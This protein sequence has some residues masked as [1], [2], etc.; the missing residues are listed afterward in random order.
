[1]KGKQTTKQVRAGEVSCEHATWH[2][3][4][5][6]VTVGVVVRKDVD[7]QLA[8]AL[9]LVPLLFAE[10]GRLREREREKEKERERK[11]RERERE[12]ERKLWLKGR[13]HTLQRESSDDTRRDPVSHRTS[14]SA[15][16]SAAFVF[17]PV[18]TVYGVGGITH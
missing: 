11:R 18:W 2:N 8:P 7:R 6:V 12:R 10:D 5:H 3:A 17:R 1:M 15:F 16:C 9:S 4:L 14:P 13:I